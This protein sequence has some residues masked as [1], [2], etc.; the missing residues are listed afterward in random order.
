MSPSTRKLREHSPVREKRHGGRKE[1]EVR[2]VK[3]EDRACTYVRMYSYVRGRER[4]VGGRRRQSGGGSFL[5]VFRYSSL[6]VDE[7]SYMQKCEA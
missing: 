3:R 6:A 7:R 5:S 2:F 1:E 4:G